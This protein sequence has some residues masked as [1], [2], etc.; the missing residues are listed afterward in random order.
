VTV[1][2][3]DIADFRCFYEAGRMVAAGSDPYDRAAWAAATITDP[4]R[5]PHCAK[6]F[7]YPLW[8]AL[9]MAPLSVLPER[10]AVALWEAVLFACA[11]GG[12]ALIA[13]TWSMLGGAKLLLVTFLWSQPMFSA[14]GNAQFGPVMLVC[15]AA[16]AFS[17]ER[18]RIRTGAA[19]WWLLLLK[20]HITALVMAGTLFAVSRRAAAAL[21]AGAV[22]IGLASLPL[23]PTW[24]VQ[25]VRE[26]LDQQQLLGDRGLGTLWTLSSDL[27]LPAFVGGGIALLLVLGFAALLPRGALRP[28]EIVAALLAAS[29]LLTPYARPHDLVVLAVCWGAALAAAKQLESGARARLVI[30]TIATGLV[31]PWLVTLLSLFGAPLS[32][33]V[34]VSLAS[35]MLLLIALRAE[36]PRQTST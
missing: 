19:A 29:L 1:R 13:H 30:G 32:L 22:V 27:G 26:N 12:I 23:I 9:A 2:D 16:L 17:L 35:A 5:V 18:G 31:V 36:P 34:L 8:T 6:T 24:P 11:L 33:Y 15:V 3:A 10:T 21:I 25:L 4:E 14:I 28:R 7:I 20:P